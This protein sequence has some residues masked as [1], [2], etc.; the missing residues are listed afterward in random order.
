MSRMI[1]KNRSLESR[2]PNSATNWLRNAAAFGGF[3]QRRESERQ[4]GRRQDRQQYRATD[5]KKGADREQENADD[6]AVSGRHPH[7]IDAVD[8]QGITDDQRL[9]D[10]AVGPG[11]VH[12]GSLSRRPASIPPT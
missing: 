12:D 1:F 2:L 5:V 10:L 6:R 4:Y 7:I 3:D 9:A 11:L 8:G